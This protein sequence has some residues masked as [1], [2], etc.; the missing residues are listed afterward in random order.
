NHPTE[1]ER[2]DRLLLAHLDVLDAGGGFMREL[3]PLGRDLGEIVENGVRR[4]QRP[5]AAGDRYHARLAAEDLAAR[6]RRP[7][8]SFGS[9]GG[10]G[11]ESGGMGQP[12]DGP[13]S[14]AAEQMA[15]L[16]DAL[17]QLRQEH[18][19]QMHDVE[20]ALRDA[21]PAEERQALQEQ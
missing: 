18:A 21:L 1:R 16:E 5:F 6:L 13:P 20:Q 19:R 9:A 8:P 11:V 3:G 14:E 17:E 15:G 7:D 10:G 2:A 12:G 4:I